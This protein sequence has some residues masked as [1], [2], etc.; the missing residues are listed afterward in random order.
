MNTLMGIVVSNLFIL[1]LLGISAVFEKKSLMRPEGTRKLIHI[2]AC[3]WWFIAMFYFDSSLTAAIVPVMFVIVNVIQY[4]KHLF[5]SMV[6]T[7]S[8]SNHEKDLGPI[9]YAIS[10][11]VLA[12]WS[13]GIGRPE[14]GGIGVLIMGYADGLAALVGKRHGKVKLI[15]GKT[16][17]GTLT[18]FVVAALVVVGFNMGFGLGL[19]VFSII[20]VA[21]FATIAELCTPKGLD[22]LLVPIGSSL[23]VYWLVLG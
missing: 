3:N 20:V 8:K 10:L 12:I 1:I 15:H 19:G 16:I 2:G 14:V 21:L 6:R 18:G 22:N 7:D 4:K 13:F 23:L 11:L 17:A 9:Y 5:T